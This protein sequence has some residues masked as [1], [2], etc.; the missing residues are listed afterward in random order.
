MVAQPLREEVI[1]V[2]DS[3]RIISDLRE[4]TDGCMIG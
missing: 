1:R 4:E 3:R 2:A